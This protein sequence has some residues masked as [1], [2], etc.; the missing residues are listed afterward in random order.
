MTSRAL[1]S[2]WINGLFKELV[3]LYGASFTRQWQALD[4]E[5]MKRIWLRELADFTSEEISRGL[6]ACRAR[7]FPP[8]VPEFRNLCRP[9]PLDAE[10]AFFEAARLWPSRVGWSDPAIYWAAQ[11]IG[12]DVKRLGYPAIKA[13]WKL[14]YERARARPQLLPL[15]EE[16]PRLELRPIDPQERANAAERVLGWCRTNMPTFR[17]KETS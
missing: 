8:T 12:N 13:R 11:A 7:E 16:V 2:G 15:P 17:G 5:E 10:A 6:Q 3:G 9:P 14:A 4:P 1:Q